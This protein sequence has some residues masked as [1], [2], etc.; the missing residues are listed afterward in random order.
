[1]ARVGDGEL[2]DDRGPD[3]LDDLVEA[4]IQ[5]SVADRRAE[6]GVVAAAEGGEPGPVALRVPGGEHGLAFGDPQRVRRDP[7]VEP[8]SRI[9]ASGLGGEELTD[10]TEQFGAGRAVMRW[11]D[12]IRQVLEG[13]DHD[14]RRGVAQRE[15]DVVFLLANPAAE[16]RELDRRLVLREIPLGLPPAE[17]RPSHRA[18]QLPPALGFLVRRGAAARGVTRHQVGPGPESAD[19]ARRAEPPGLGAQPAQVLPGITAMS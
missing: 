18:V 8:Q 19:G 6:P 9:C 2:V 10:G 16:H 11:R 3:R 1:M 12:M 7:G 5:R 17:Q 15:Q 4:V 14:H 13:I